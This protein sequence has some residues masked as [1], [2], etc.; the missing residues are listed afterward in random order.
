MNSS[1]LKK[2]VLALSVVF[3]VSCDSDYSEIGADIIDDDI[4][5]NGIV[6]AIVNVTAFDKATGAVQANNMPINSLGVYDNPAFGKTTAHFVS[7]VAIPIGSENPTFTDVTIDTVY[8]YIPYTSQR[9]GTDDNGDG[10]YTV[11]SGE[12][13]KRSDNAKVR[14]SVYENGYYLRDTDPGSS[15]GIQKYYSDD[16]ALVDNFKGPL[17]AQSDFVFD[18]K[19]WVRERV[20]DPDQTEVIE[21]LAPGIYMELDTLFFRNKVINAASQGK[22]L[23]NSVFQD[24]FRGIY[25]TAEQVDNQSNMALLDFSKGKIIIRYHEGDDITPDTEFKTYTLNLTGNTINFFDNVYK[26]DF[27]TGINNSNETGEGDETIYLKGGE[28]SVAYININ[29]SD[30]NFLSEGNVLINEANLV[31]TIDQAKLA[32]GSTQAPIEPL[33]IYLYDVN[34]RRPI[35]DYYTDATTNGSDARYNKYVYG[36]IIEKDGGKGVRYK[37]RLTDQINN[38]VK[39]ADST[40]VT[41]GLSVTNDISAIANAALRTPFEVPGDPDDSPVNEIKSIPVSSVINPLGTILYGS[42]FNVAEDKRLKLEIYY[43]KPN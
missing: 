40:N 16:K 38:L 4:H 33:R 28:G 19:E 2:F 7:Q 1:I 43:T 21:R 15:D 41:L 30:L 5:H 27:L 24:Y 32:G 11:K 13:I 42:S 39:N 6:K 12:I 29:R 34:N 3:L 26:N 36:G 23:N 17:L 14:L 8:I 25:I 22:L 9:T 31:F 10:I 35:Y 37:L 18:E 20:I